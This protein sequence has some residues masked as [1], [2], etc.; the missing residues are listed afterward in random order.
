MIIDNL[1]PSKNG[2]VN[3]DGTLYYY[4][5]GVRNYAV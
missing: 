1:D 5:N 2:I 3:E 4:V